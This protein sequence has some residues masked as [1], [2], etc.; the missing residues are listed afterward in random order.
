MNIEERYRIKAII[1]FND[2]ITFLRDPHG[3]GHPKRS[4][5]LAVKLALELRLANGFIE[6]VEYG[7]K[8]HDIGKNMIEE[9]ILNKPKLTVA[10]MGMVRD[11]TKLGMLAIIPMHFDKSIEDAIH[12]HHEN[13]DGSG[14]PNGLKREE[15]PLIARI[16]AITDRFDA[17]THQRAYHD[18][19]SLEDAIA[20][21][22]KDIGIA[23]D[24]TIFMVFKRMMMLDG[25]E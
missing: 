15:I 1:E 2:S 22:D 11:H 14:Y 24:P 10:E 13:W 16:G 18:I 9:A 3:D 8:L 12:F 21:M 23:F 6:L 17:M 20:E 19:Y 5:L 4:S 25:H 7:M